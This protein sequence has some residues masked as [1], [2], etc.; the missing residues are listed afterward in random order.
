MQLRLKTLMQVQK[1]FMPV[2]P[3]FKT[4]HV[5]SENIC[6]SPFENIQALCKYRPTIENIYASSEALFLC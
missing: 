5:S 4:F 6:A 1:T 2:G 3:R